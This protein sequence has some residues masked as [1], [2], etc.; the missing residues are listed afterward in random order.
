MKTLLYFVFLSLFTFESIAQTQRLV[1]V[2]EFTN[3]SCG[4][5]ALSN[6][7]FNALMTANATKVVAIRNHTSFPGYDPFYAQNTVQNQSRTIYYQVTNVPTARMD[8]AGVFL[9]DVNQTSIDAAYAVAPIY[10]IKINYH[11]SNDNDSLYATA[12]VKALSFNTGTLKAHIVVVEK[13]ISLTTPPGSNGETDFPMVMKKMLPSEAGTSLPGTMFPG[14]SVVINVGWL[15]ANVFNI[16]Q[17]AVVCFV[18]DNLNKNVKQAAYA[19]TP[20]SG[21]PPTPPTIALNTLTNTMCGST[22]AININVSGGTTPYSYIWSNNATSEDISG[23]ETGTYSVTVIGGTATSVATYTIQQVLSQPTIDSMSA[24]TSCSIKMNWTVVNGAATYKVRYKTTSSSTWNTEI[25]A[26]NIN[27]Y[28][29]NGLASGTTYNFEVAACC[30]NGYNSGFVGT[31]DFTNECKMI[32]SSSV[33]INSSTSATVSW[34]APCYSIGYRIIYKMTSS[35]VW[36]S[37]FIWGTTQFTITNLL[38]N[39]SYEYR[40]RNRCGDPPNVTGWTSA[41]SFTTP[42]MRIEDENT[43]VNSTNT[44]MLVYPNPT[45]DLFNLSGSFNEN[46]VEAQIKIVNTLGQ[47]VFQSII[48]LD[49]G[50]YDLPISLTS[51]ISD[52]LYYVNVFSNNEKQESQLLIQR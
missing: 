25:I 39:T 36:S 32:T 6:P 3:A 38:P 40:L 44:S 7:A 17:L 12:T 49:K 43:I 10:S 28:V 41:I 37:A 13:M 19:P 2:E 24:K 51:T 11:I 5:C 52:G 31:T 1:L 45:S 26:G 21:P 48:T 27:N 33:T 47:I 4:P 42:A 18:Q 22:G 14:D 8:G 9:S 29:F 15:L 50:T 46:N 34:V 16:N 30:L 20:F 23:L 35:S